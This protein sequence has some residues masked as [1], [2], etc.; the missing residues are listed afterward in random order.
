MIPER[1]VLASASPRR[2]EILGKFG[3]GFDVIPSDADEKIS[4]DVPCG[5]YVETLAARKGKAVRDALA[6]EGDVS[7]T[8]IISC[9]TVVY[10]D[11]MII[12]KPESDLHA[13]LTIGMLSD[14]W[15]DVYSG[16][17]LMFDGKTVCAHDVTHVKFADIPERDIDRYVASGEPRGKAGSYAIQGAASAFVEKIDGDV[18]NVIGFPLTLFCRLIK[19]NFGFSVFD[20]GE[21]NDA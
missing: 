1:I 21:R 12:G 9:D 14:S 8:L 15:H 3:F 7:G 6:A 20:L 17:C 19:E 10:F 11:K 5:E 16:I 4:S 18:Y 2:R 13:R